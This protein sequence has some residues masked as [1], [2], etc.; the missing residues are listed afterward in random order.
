MHTKKRNRLLHK[1]LND[2]VYVSYNRKMLSRFQKRKEKADKSFDPLVL[3]D[4][5]WDNEWVD[6]SVVHADSSRNDDG[7]IDLTM[8]RPARRRGSGSTSA[9]EQEDE[10]CE[11][12]DGGDDPSYDQ[13]DDPCDDIYLSD[14]DE[15]KEGEDGG[16]G[17]TSPFRDEFD[18]GY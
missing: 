5:D 9:H 18:D 1:R 2:L 13:E 14:S 11:Q 17:N 15:E 6:S 10:Q 4:F 7:I 8:T 12:E 3:E 16:D